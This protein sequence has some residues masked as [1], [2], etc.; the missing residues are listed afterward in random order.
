MTPP[1][2]IPFVTSQWGEIVSRQ[3]K[4]RDNAVAIK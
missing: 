1:G 3:V 4:I 2:S